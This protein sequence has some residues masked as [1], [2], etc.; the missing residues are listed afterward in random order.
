MNPNPLVEI[1]EFSVDYESKSGPIHALDSISLSI[2]ENRLIAVVGESG[3]GKTTL[4][5][6]II[7][8]LAKP[9]AKYVSGKLVYKGT[10]LLTLDNDKVRFF[11]RDR[12]S[13]G[14]SRAHEF[15]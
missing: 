12:N 7:G 13:H 4:G 11:R 8:L 10:N 1:S 6:A 15:P 5:L 9:P 2:E 3:S 14:V